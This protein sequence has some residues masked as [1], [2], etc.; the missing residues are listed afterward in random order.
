MTEGDTERLTVEDLRLKTTDEGPV[1]EIGDEISVLLK[2]F[3]EVDDETHFESEADRFKTDV[4][5]NGDNGAWW[6]IW[7]GD[8]LYPFVSIQP[9]VVRDV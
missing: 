2:T 6:M 9:E 4:D 5:S 8:D 7:P 3:V 1:L